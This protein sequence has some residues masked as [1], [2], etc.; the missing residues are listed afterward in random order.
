M[1]KL[2]TIELVPKTCWYSNVRSNISKEEWDRIRK[3]V[4][5]RAG[6]MCEICGG[7]GN[8]WPVECHEMWLYDDERHIQKLVKL[9]ALC[10]SCHEVKHLGLA[11]TRGREGAAMTHLAKVNNWS[12]TDAQHYVEAAFETWHQR[13]RH[14]WTLDISCLV[15]FGINVPV[16]IPSTVRK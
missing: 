3:I 13:S 15:Q 2:L 11:G 12:T 6:N 14:H 4:F 9:I 8:Q 7:H 5:N 1:R 10:P 16:P